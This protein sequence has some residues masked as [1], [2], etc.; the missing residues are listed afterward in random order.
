MCWDD[1][2]LVS[3]FD[4][5]SFERPIKNK[6]YFKDIDDWKEKNWNGHYYHGW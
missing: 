1:H 6:Y 4:G 5:I 2:D 3:S